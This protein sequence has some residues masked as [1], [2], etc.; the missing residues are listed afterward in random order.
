MTSL[1]ELN[2]IWIKNDRQA[3]N[4]VKEH[5][6]TM[7]DRSIGGD[8]GDCVYRAY[9][10]EDGDWE[11]DPAIVYID[12]CCA[13]GCLIKDD[14]YGD[15]L[16]GRMIEFA[17]GD[18]SVADSVKSSHPDWVM[19]DLSIFMMKCFQLIHDRVGYPS[20]WKNAIDAFE[21]FLVFDG[22]T[23]VDVKSVRDTIPSYS[24]YI[25][26]GNMSSKDILSIIY[27][28]VHKYMNRF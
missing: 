15:W 24:H 18:T 6:L 1:V 2:K 9:E 12:N 28:G 16:E 21:S 19:T 4:V 3:F 11:E 22:D 8:G 27:D 26:E 25:N 7:P 5:L 20:Y 10:Y 23:I 17:Y 14:S 13:V